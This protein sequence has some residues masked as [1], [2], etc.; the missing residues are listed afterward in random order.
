MLAVALA[1]LQGSSSQD[2][3]LYQQFELT[4]AGLT[5]E[6]T[7]LPDRPIQWQ[8]D[9]TKIEISVRNSNP[10]ANGTL[11]PAIYE[12]IPGIQGQAR[13]PLRFT[14]GTV[15]PSWYDVT[16]T[17]SKAIMRDPPG[18]ADTG[19]AATIRFYVPGARSLKD[20]R[21]RWVGK[22]VWPLGAAAY[23]DEGSE[24]WDPRKPAVITSNEPSPGEWGN[25]AF[26]P[27]WS[28]D[29]GGVGFI[30]RAPLIFRLSLP[31][32]PLHR[33]S[34]GVGRFGPSFYPPMPG[35]AQ[36]FWTTPEP[37]RKR[38]AAQGH[39]Y[40]AD[41]WQIGRMLTVRP[42]TQA[43]RHCGRRVPWAFVRRQI[44]PGMPRE[45][46]VRLVGFPRQDEDPAKQWKRPNWYFGGPAPFAYSIDFDRRGLV[47][48][49]QLEG[50]L[51]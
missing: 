12:P 17:A 6:L 36:D 34:T 49:S 48:K 38:G 47:K 20:M 18:W 13:L 46:A 23:T 24:V 8:L 43:L 25:V 26:N 28:E 35:V 22:Q 5:L 37:P 41:E 45:L 3:R 44:V 31:D 21:A 9:P 16:A 50:E 39:L 42:P 29:F 30:S 40:I 7:T 11:L 27:Q 14:S 4:K 32:I 1:I 33:D 15:V 51:P 2:L 10:Q 19:D